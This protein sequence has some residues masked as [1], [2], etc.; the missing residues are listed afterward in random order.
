MHSLFHQVLV[1]KNLSKA[2]ELFSLEDRFIINDFDEVMTKILDIVSQPDFLINHND[3]SLVE[4]CITRLTSA[5]RETRT[6]ESHAGSMVQLLEL[7]LSYNLR[8]SA[9]GL[10]PPHAKIAS[11]LMSCIFLNYSKRNVMEL[12][13]PVAVKFLH[14]GNKDLS[15]NM[16]SYLSLAAIEHAELLAQHI[17]PIIDSVISGNYSLARV[18][19]TI[20]GVNKN[21]IN[22]HVMTLVSIL[23][24]CE[25]TEK[26]A[27]LSL[28][29]LV[30]KDNSALLEP[31]VPQ[32]CESLTSQTT[33]AATLQ[34]LYNIALTKPLILADHTRQLR[35]TAENFPKSAISAIQVMSAIAKV[36]KEKAPETMDFITSMIGRLEAEKHSMVLKEIIALTNKYPTLLTSNLMSKL[37]SLEEGASSASRTYIQ[38][39]RNEFNTRSREK[40][41]STTITPAGALNHGV[42]I[43]KVGGGS[44]SELSSQGHKIIYQSTQV[45]GPLPSKFDPRYTVSGSRSKLPHTHRSMTKLN[46][47]TSSSG[48]NPIGSSNVIASGGF[49]SRM[50]LHKSMTKLSASSQQNMVRYNSGSQVLTQPMARSITCITSGQ[51]KPIYSA[52]M[53]GSMAGSNVNGSPTKSMSSGSMSGVAGGTALTSSSDG[54]DILTVNVNQINADLMR[55]VST[56]LSQHQDITNGF[57]KVNTSSYTHLASQGLPAPPTHPHSLSAVANAPFSLPNNSSRRVPPYNSGPL[58]VPSSSQPPSLG[59][60]LAPNPATTSH[61][62]I[63]HH[64]HHGNQ[65][66]NYQPNPRPQSM[67]SNTLPSPRRRAAMEKRDEGD[68]MSTG[69]VDDGL[70]NGKSKTQNRMSVFEPFPMRD[71]VQHFCEKHL[72]KIKSYMTSLMAK[73]PL[74]VKCTIEERKG[75]KHAKLHFACQGREGDH[76]LYKSTFYTLKT[77]NPKIWIHLMFLALQARSQSAISTRESS[78]SALKHCW[79][80]LKSESMNFVTLVTGAFPPAKDQDTLLNELRSHRFFD[81]FEYNG[82]RQHWGCFLCNHPDR[83]EDFIQDTAP[84]IEGQ[85]KEKKGGKWKLFKK[86]KSRYFTL[87]GAKLM[88]KEQGGD[89]GGTMQ[90]LDV[91]SIRSV[92]VTKEGRRNIPKAFEIFTHDK[93]FI[94]KAKDGSNA[95]EWVQCLSVAKA[96]CES[97]DS[98]LRKVAYSGSLGR[99]NHHHGRVPLIH[100]RSLTNAN[101]AQR[102]AV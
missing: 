3:Q 95:Q 75:K 20:Y 45:Q 30:A 62:P 98:N 96:H 51:G 23:H 56:V 2:G 38:E 5:I 82:P 29:G 80:I 48:P 77:R 35:V 55:Q 68:P 9:H 65:P 63:Y 32:L 93:T 46:M 71:T 67:F 99:L 89:N 15:R 90:T 47:Q 100:Q 94:L 27:L 88:Y 69:S 59:I 87:S 12:A 85:L 11:D 7:C 8:P 83:A 17:Q 14:K 52:G 21:P 60:P 6:I 57:P 79:E 76:C 36:K 92:K 73:L 41:T 43:V 28:F 70:G 66:N 13:L 10:D 31:S 25:N 26:L 72:D 81:V 64:H 44:K 101:I 4:I 49:D 61:Y 91:G 37:T 97:R 74:P 84:V 18:L 40:L 86:W 39:L 19:P 53:R 102:T 54:R 1:Q 78:V 24:N 33:A 34:V 22:N 50:G 58:P 42:T 16:S